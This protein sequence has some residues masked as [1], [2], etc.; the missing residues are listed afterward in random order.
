MAWVRQTASLIWITEEGCHA[1]LS[2]FFFVT[3]SYRLER[4]ETLNTASAPF[5]V[6]QFPLYSLLVLLLSMAFV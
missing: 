3:E 5:L 2:T 1:V 4:S 6:L